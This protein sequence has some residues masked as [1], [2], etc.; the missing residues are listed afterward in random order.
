MPKSVL[1]V[2][3]GEIVC[4]EPL[5]CIFGLK[6][7]DILVYKSLVSKGP[8]KIDDLGKHIDR[9][10]STIYRALQTLMNHKL[11]FR[12]M[13]TIKNGGY[14]YIYTATAPEKVSRSMQ[15]HVDE[16]Y[17]KMTGILKKFTEEFKPER[18]V[19]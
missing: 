9:E 10:Q 8:M 4:E 11:V 2:I 14:F 7:L 16:W 12:E 13:K 19:R 1:E 18:K 17:K 5:D 6:K 3:S 15:K